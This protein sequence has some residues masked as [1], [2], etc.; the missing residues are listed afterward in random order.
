MAHARSERGMRAMRASESRES[1]KPV[2]A[3]AF[4]QWEQ[5]QSTALILA[6][7]GGAKGQ[8]REWANGQGRRGRASPN[9]GGRVR[10]CVRLGGGGGWPA[11]RS[12]R[13]AFFA[14]R[15]HRINGRAPT[16]E[17]KG[18]AF[19]V[20]QGKGSFLIVTIYMVSLLLLLLFVVV[21]VVVVAV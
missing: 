2:E 17:W 21:V 10:V 8:G 3:W 12:T 20:D 4:A 13:R 6:G 9:L 11:G 15:A 18:S 5:E 19:V 16:S 7:G 14:V 1:R